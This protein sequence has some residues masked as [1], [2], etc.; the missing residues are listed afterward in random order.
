MHHF[1]YNML[2]YF[3]KGKNA[4]HMQ[5]KRFVQW[6]EKV[7][8][9]MKRVKSGLRSFALEISCWM[10]LHG[11]V[12]QSMLYHVADRWHPQIIQVN[13]VIGEN[14]KC[15]FYFMENPYGL[16]A[17]PIFEKWVFLSIVAGERQGGSYWS[18]VILS[19]WLSMFPG[20]LKRS[21]GTRCMLV[22]R[23]GSDLSILKRPDSMGKGLACSGRMLCRSSAWNG[24]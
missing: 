3:K 22:G 9:L 20:P 8:W 12:E 23:N 1:R 7:L 13:N 6:M 21:V 11:R 24:K 10:M 17:N 19:C 18:W 14:E 16:L 2:H 5:K 15:V 4:T